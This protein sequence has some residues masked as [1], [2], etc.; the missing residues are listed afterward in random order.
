MLLKHKIKTSLWP[1]VSHTHHPGNTLNDKYETLQHVE[2][3]THAANLKK[4]TK[5]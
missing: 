2:G 5:N 4:Q 1:Y 3:F